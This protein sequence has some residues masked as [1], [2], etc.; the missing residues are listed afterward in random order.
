M[1]TGSWQPLLSEAVHFKDRADLDRQISLHESLLDRYQDDADVGFRL[2]VT[3]RLAWLL[4]S[5]GRYDEA[6]PLFRNTLTARER[7][8]GPDHPDTL[9]SRNNLAVL[10]SRTGRYD[11]AEPLLRD[12]LATATRVLGPDHPITQTVVANLERLRVARLEAQ[13]PI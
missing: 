1:A 10:L 3:R 12:T 5:T 2:D 13:R 11:E 8:L 9:S 7:V 4:Y 6:E